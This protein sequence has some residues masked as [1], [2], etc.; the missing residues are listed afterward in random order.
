MIT[1][2]NN[3]CFLKRHSLSTHGLV[4]MLLMFIV[5]VPSQAIP[6]QPGLKRD[7]LGPRAVQVASMVPFP[8]VGRSAGSSAATELEAQ[9]DDGDNT[10][11]APIQ[12]QQQHPTTRTKRQALIPFP[13]TGK[14]SAAVG[15]GSRVGPSSSVHLP[16]SASVWQHYKR[17][18]QWSPWPIYRLLVH[19][20]AQHFSSLIP[21][22][23]TGKRS[24]PPSPPEEAKEDAWWRK[25]GGDYLY[26]QSDTTG[27]GSMRPRYQDRLHDYLRQIQMNSDEDQLT[28]MGDQYYPYY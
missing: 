15:A 6:V 2:P 21:F 22:P 27:G 1:R 19:K 11:T 18:S 20:K 7:A 12:K 25:L 14:R 4:A 23:R 5:N 8:R 28:S 13:R 24:A 3:G 26:E 16:V 17:R 9:K 10:L